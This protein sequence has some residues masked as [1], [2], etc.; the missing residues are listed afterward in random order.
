M[1][2]IVFVLTNRDFEHIQRLSKDCGLSTDD[3]YVTRLSS[4]ALFLMGIDRPVLF[5]EM[6]DNRAPQGIKYVFN[7]DESVN[8][9]RNESDGSAGDDLRGKLS[10]LGFDRTYFERIHDRLL[11]KPWFICETERCIIRETTE[12]DVDSFYELYSD[13]QITEFTEGLFPDREE[14]I[15]YTRDYRE[16]VYGFYEYGIWTV[17]DRDTGEVIGRAGLTPREGF[18]EP[19]IGFVIGKRWQGKGIATEVCRRIIDYGRE[20]LGF[21]TIRAFVIRENEVS[22]RLLSKLGFNEAG[23]EILNGIEHIRMKMEL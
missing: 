14:E 7:T 21:T 22:F 15:A 4:A 13:P 16:K 9:C 17:L 1:R 23:T 11:N 10:A 6:G 18:D 8:Y 12:D 3:L 5:W 2:E 19:E 20:E